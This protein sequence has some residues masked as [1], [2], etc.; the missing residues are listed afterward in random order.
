M[1]RSD[2]RWSSDSLEFRCFNGD[3]VSLR[4]LM[5]RCD[6]EV[7]SFVAKRGKELSSWMAKEQVVLAVC[8]RFGALD[9]Q[10]FD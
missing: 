5:D 3:I 7:I 6:R 10:R 2:T 4:F 8:Q 1:D 9:L